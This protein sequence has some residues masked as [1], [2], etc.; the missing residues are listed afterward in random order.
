MSYQIVIATS[1]HIE[2]IEAYEWYEGRQVGLGERFML[3][4]E[5]TLDYISNYPLHYS[6][7]KARFR[8]A[9]VSVFP[10]QIVY[11]ASEKYKTVYVSAI[12]HSKRNPKK[13]YR[14]K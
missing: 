8:E 11:E 10:F 13:K 12:Y 14:K 6:I 2:Y 5:E 9:K 1:A 3:H 4:V 7:K